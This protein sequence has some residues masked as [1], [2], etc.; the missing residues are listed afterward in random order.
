MPQ[1]NE[2]MIAEIKNVTQELVNTDKEQEGHYWKNLVPE[3]TKLAERGNGEAA[4]E[5]GR[6]LS[7]GRDIPPHFGEAIRLLELAVEAGIIEAKA[8][9]I[10][11]V[12]KNDHD[13]E[14]YAD[15]LKDVVGDDPTKTQ[16]T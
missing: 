12:L 13:L 6:L 16:F 15:M 7:H 2:D 11:C 10:Y 8:P 4:L 9:L 1:L 3:L 5:A 14:K